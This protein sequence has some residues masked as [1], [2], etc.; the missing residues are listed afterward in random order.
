MDFSN[1]YIK[2]IKNGELE[3]IQFEHFNKTGLVSHC[4]TTRKGGVSA[5]DFES[6]NLKYNLGD[7]EENVNK[8]REIIGKEL[9]FNTDAVVTSPQVHG[10]AVKVVDGSTLTFTDCDG[11]ISNKPGVCLATFYADC[12]PLLFFDP[13]K[14]VIANSHAGWRGTVAKIGQKTVKKMSDQFGCKPKDILVGIGPSIGQC[15]F[16]TGS[17][18]AQ[19]FKENFENFNDISIQRDDKYHID[20]WKANKSQLEEIGVSNEN[21]YISGICTACN[22]KDFFSYRGNNRNTGRIGSFIQIL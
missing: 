2:H 20:L 4:M 7:S 5:G 18:V 21:V 11:F 15:C 8:N 3:Y 12:V 14:K 1:R 16:E 19:R 9:G 13:V 22:K 6:L 17:E 10:D